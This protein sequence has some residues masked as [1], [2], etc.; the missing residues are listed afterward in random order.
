[1][2][3]DTP[4]TLV[5]AATLNGDSLGKRALESLC[6]AY[7]PAVVNFLR[8]R[9]LCMEESEDL[10]Q[11]FFSALVESRL[12][13]RADQARGRF[14]SF[15]LGALMRTLSKHVRYQQA[16]KR[17]K[18]AMLIALDE[19]ADQG[20]ELAAEDENERLRFDRAWAERVL[21]RAMERLAAEWGDDRE[22]ATLQRF[23]PMGE[24]APAYEAAA[25]ELGCTLPALK[26]RVHRFRQRFREHIESEVARTVSEPHEVAEELRYLERV[27]LDPGFEMK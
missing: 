1:M 5:A 16:A 18:N 4:W 25:N 15:L 19:L 9:G 2:F 27:L 3:P 10:A 23:L 21:E 24:D 8:G 12:W 6:Q 22:L 7:W 11:D 20:G 14:R 13:H 26:L 17:G